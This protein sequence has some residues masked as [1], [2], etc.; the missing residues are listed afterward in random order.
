MNTAHSVEHAG[1]DHG[2]IHGHEEH[3]HEETFL[4]KYIFSQDH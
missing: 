3:H 1:V 4:T 2:H